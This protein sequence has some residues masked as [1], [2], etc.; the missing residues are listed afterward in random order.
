M[1]QYLLYFL[2]GGVL[3]ATIA[4]VGSQHGGRLAAVVGS[5]PVIFL[6][7]LVLMY[8]SGG[9]GASVEHVRGTLT[10]RRCSLSTRC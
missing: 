4:Y 5:V 6:M 2:I 9:V 1:W 3:V 10:L 8:R 7:S